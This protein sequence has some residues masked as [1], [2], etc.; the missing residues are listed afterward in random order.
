MDYDKEWIEIEHTWEDCE[1]LERSY[2]EYD[3]GYAEY[4]CNLLDDQCYGEAMCP[5]VCKYKV[6][7]N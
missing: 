2:Y 4:D 5:L 6:L 1:Y 3:T 7:K